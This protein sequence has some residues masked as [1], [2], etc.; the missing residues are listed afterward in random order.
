MLTLHLLLNVIT[1]KYVSPVILDFSALSVQPKNYDFKSLSDI[2]TIMKCCFGIMAVEPPQFRI[3]TYKEAASV[4][5][6]L[7]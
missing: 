6:K 4:I 3:C 5:E 7:S 2:E 1:N